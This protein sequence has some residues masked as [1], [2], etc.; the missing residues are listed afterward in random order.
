MNSL[1]DVCSADLYDISSQVLGNDSAFRFR[2]WG[3]SMDGCIKNGE[4][5][6]VR[7][8]KSEELVPGDIIFFFC[9][10][11]PFVHRLIRKEN[12][13]KKIVIWAKG[14]QVQGFDACLS[15]EDILGKVVAV[16]RAGK[17][18]SLDYGNNNLARNLEI[19]RSLIRPQYYGLLFRFKDFARAASKIVLSKKSSRFILKRF[20]PL[21]DVLIR[22]ADEGTL[23]NIYA[24]FN[25]HDRPAEGDFWLAAF[26][27]KKVVACLSISLVNRWQKDWSLSTMM[28]KTLFRGRGIAEKLCLA[29]MEEVK[30][31]NGL[32]LFLKVS[33]ENHAA[34]GLYQKLGFKPFS[35]DASVDEWQMIKEL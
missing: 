30:K 21:K 12:T 28:T 16:R 34:F 27:R 6:E 2:A 9:E 32:R 24:A 20:F 26:F 1:I 22:V 8:M 5:I 7:R 23:E 35:I 31:R 3:Q 33:T 29:A 17:W 19:A 15:P 10:G 14:D 11:H 25:I 13:G 18:L 4:Y